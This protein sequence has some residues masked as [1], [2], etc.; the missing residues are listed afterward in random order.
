MDDVTIVVQPNTT[1]LTVAPSE[2]T[3]LFNPVGS[4]GIPGTGAR[5]SSAFTGAIDGVNTAFTMTN[6]P[7]N[8]LF[9][10]FLNGLLQ[11]SND[12]SLSGSTV[13]FIIAPFTGDT[14][15]FFYTY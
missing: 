2:V 10:C 6:T 13:T 8:A 14:L 11:G 5:F 15:Q 4:Q 3:L 12:F 9:L 1:T 7:S